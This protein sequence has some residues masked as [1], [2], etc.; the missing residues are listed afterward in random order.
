MVYIVTKVKLLRAAEELAKDSSRNGRRGEH[1]SFRSV[2]GQ[3]QIEFLD[4][5]AF[6]R[7]Y[8]FPATL[9]NVREAP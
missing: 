4:T 6:F 3:W 2:R 9:C 7:V 8:Y 1:L 5:T